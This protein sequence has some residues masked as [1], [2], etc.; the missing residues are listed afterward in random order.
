[1]I[2]GQGDPAGQRIMNDADIQIQVAIL[3]KLRALTGDRRKDPGEQLIHMLT[4][5]SS[6]LQPRFEL[7]GG[8]I[9]DVS[10]EPSLVPLVV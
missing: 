5:G 4:K 2:L 10:L 9:P 8:H 3:R 7:P 6:T 1:M